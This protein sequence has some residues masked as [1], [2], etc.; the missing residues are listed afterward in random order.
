MQARTSQPELEAAVSVTA[1][2]GRSQ[3]IAAIDWMRGLVMVLMIIDHASMAFDK[4]HIAKDSAMY[5]DAGT[6]SLPAGEFFT[7]WITHLCAPTSVFLAG[8]ALALSVERRVGKGAPAIEI[9][10]NIIKH[11]AII[12]LLDLT[13]ISLG[14][15]YLNLGVLLAI[16]LSMICMAPLRRLPSVALLGLAL[17]WMAL[18][19]LVTD[20]AWDPPGSASP[21]ASFLVATSANS[22]V[23]N[24]HPLIP[25]LAIMMLGWVLGR[26]MV[27]FNA[28]KTRLSPRTILLVGGVLGLAVFGIV[29]GL[30][31]YGDMFLPRADGS[32]QQWLHVSKYPPSLSFNGLELGLL[33]CSLAFLMTIEP[34]IGVLEVPATYFRLRG[35]GNIVTTCVTSGVLLV[36]LYPACRGF[37]LS[38]QLIRIPC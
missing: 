28:G 37:A 29:R 5:P 35:A 27:G 19:E 16:G 15:G 20:W 21:L 1:P 31:G 36:L 26:H 38:K 7:R 3:R 23:V 10:R 24:K 22:I 34:I 32:W 25:W 9:D 17:G 30:H 18:G 33:C 12:G 6:M 14:S 13:I 8:T 11:G 2:R 4:D